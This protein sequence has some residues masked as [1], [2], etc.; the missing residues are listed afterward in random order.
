MN[1]KDYTFVDP[2]G[3]AVGRKLEALAQKHPFR[4]GR[5]VTALEEFVLTD[6]N[7]AY[8][9]EPGDPGQIEIYMVPPRNVLVH[10]PDSAALIRVDHPR[11]RIELVTIFEEYGGHGEKEEWKKVRDIARQAVQ[12]S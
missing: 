4:A 10:L 8:R 5:L 12:G 6:A 1:L 7:A 11:R 2:I 3:S 9:I